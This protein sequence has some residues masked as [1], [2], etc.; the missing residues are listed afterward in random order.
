MDLMAGWLELVH[1]PSHRTVTT[2]S[3]TSSI[4]VP[5]P[6]FETS[7]I[8]RAIREREPLTPS[9]SAQILPSGGYPCPYQP[10]R[11]A[12][13]TDNR[14]RRT[15][16]VAEVKPRPPATAYSIESLLAGSDS[17]SSSTSA[18]ASS[19]S[20]S[21]DIEPEEAVRP[22]DVDN[23]VGVSGGGTSSSLLNLPSS[24]SIASSSVSPDVSP[25]ARSPEAK[26]S[27]F[28]LVGGQ[29]TRAVSS[30][31][32]STPT[33]ARPRPLINCLAPPPPLD[34]FTAGLGSR[35][36]PAS[37]SSGQ[38]TP[39]LTIT[40]ALMTSLLRQYTQQPHL[41][42]PSSPSSCR[43]Q[44]PADM[45]Q[46]TAL[47]CAL[48]SGL[49]QSPTVWPLPK[50]CPVPVQSD[51][52]ST[53]LHPPPPLLVDLQYAPPGPPQLSRRP[54]LPT[55]ISVSL[56]QHITDITDPRTRQRHVY[57]Q[58]V[59]MASYAVS[60]AVASETGSLAPLMSSQLRPMP[61]FSPSS[62]RRHAVSPDN[63]H[64]QPN[65]PATWVDRCPGDGQSEEA[66]RGL[67]QLAA[68]AAA[69]AAAVAV[70]T[71]SPGCQG[72]NMPTTA[73][74][75]N[76]GCDM[77]PLA[78]S[79][80]P[81]QLASPRPLVP[82]SGRPS[83]SCSSTLLGDEAVAGS[84]ARGKS[85]MARFASGSSSGR[86]DQF[87][88][89]FNSVVGP[90]LTSTLSPCLTGLRCGGNSLASLLL[91]PSPPGLRAATPATCP[92]GD[93]VDGSRL[94]QNV[95]ATGCCSPSDRPLEDTQLP[96]ADLPA[97]HITA[98][99]SPNLNK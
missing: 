43:R 55:D 70:V 20:S 2:C 76:L 1:S 23:V 49:N 34:P 28:G 27:P 95:S 37:S 83:V 21:S 71:I 57:E 96:I 35:L 94:A 15:C 80:E 24:P 6:V 97:S 29:T 98:R 74:L 85:T 38:A 42:S 30:R 22:E 10:S 82:M 3:K 65:P 69:A 41:S 51:K 32:D 17:S 13:H 33:S 56:Q 67:W 18:S 68:A 14:V 63:C 5:A 53:H 86:L 60:E 88:E 58:P 7:T 75:P 73:Y 91:M 26:Q 8:S 78:T 62:L 93:P 48:V 36:L 50:Y 4:A 11:G 90:E 84:G 44:A 99:L 77:V 12:P 25:S 46:R 45:A 52:A 89:E 47:I 31:P 66:V 39:E 92:M 61:S 64:I 40:T 79:T 59:A 9:F 81:S 16:G 19:A 72:N 87:E 54:P